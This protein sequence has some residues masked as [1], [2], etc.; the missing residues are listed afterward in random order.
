MLNI[1]VIGLGKLGLPYALTHA[2]SGNTVYGWDHDEKVRAAVDAGESHINE[3]NI[4]EMLSRHTVTITPP[5]EMTK[6]CDVIFI[7]V[8]TPSERNG[9]FSDNHV[10]DAIRSLPLAGSCVVSIV[11]TVSPGSFTGRYALQ[12]LTERRGY[13]LFYTPTLIALGSV[14]NNLMYPDVQIVGGNEMPLP[15]KLH[16]ALASITRTDPGILVMSYESATIAKLASNVFVTMKIDFANTLAQVCDGYPGAHV[17]EV[18]NA[19][20]MN[21]RIGPKALTAGAGYGGPCFPRDA[22]AFAATGHRGA[23]LGDM[24]EKL[25]SR[26][27]YYVIERVRAMKVNTFAVLGREYKADSEYRIESWGDAL[28]KALDRFI[29]EAPITVADV[30][31]LAQPLRELK[32]DGLMKPGVIVYDLWRTHG[33][34]ANRSGVTYVQ[35]GVGRETE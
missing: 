27:R 30:V 35:L 4:P 22:A 32:L 33:Y 2:E 29:D 34:L 16:Q 23:M 19:L 24:V 7:V 15:R 3:P 9:S 28:A 1:G 6:R 25:N 21:E 12:E 11:S 31:V 8:P 10:R 5:N 13:K 20:G 17:D 18:T 14:V 26:H